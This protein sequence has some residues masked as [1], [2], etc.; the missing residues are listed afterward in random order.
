M[1]IRHRFGFI[2]LL[3]FVFF[4]F[5]HTLSAERVR[6]SVAEIYTLSTE[7]ETTGTLKIHRIVGLDIKKSEFLKGFEIQ[8]DVPKAAMEFRES[9]VFKI[10]AG[11]DKEPTE[12]TQLYRGNVV[13]E[14][15]FPTGKSLFIAVP[16][17]D[18]EKWSTSGIGV[19][20]SDRPLESEDFPLLITIGSIMKGIPGSVSKAPFDFTITPVLSD[21]GTLS[22]SLPNDIDVSELSIQIDG[23]SKKI[24]GGI[25]GEDAPRFTLNTGVHELRVGSA[26]TIPFTTTFGIEQAKTTEVKVE[27]SSA[28]SYISFEAPDEAGIFF[29]GE[30]IP[31]KKMDN[32]ETQPGEH[33]VLVQLGEYSMSK[34]IHLKKGE[35]YKI[36][37]FFDILVDED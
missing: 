22:L 20:R 7:G 28:S 34:K 31:K 13:F 27:L 23:N 37:L 29:D 11:I 15:P 17:A 19:H 8:L 30:K 35:N 5:A 21:R 6:G 18:K 1:K 10:Y 36:S 12:S 26:K 14:K 9:F 16:F 25:E 2:I 3:F 4:L 32:F 33:V 24:E